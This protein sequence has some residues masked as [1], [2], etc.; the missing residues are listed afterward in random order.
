MRF[1]SMELSELRFLW[2]WKVGQD[3]KNPP[4]ECQP[5]SVDWTPIERINGCQTA[6]V[7]RHR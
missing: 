5:K 7:A 4:L 6:P 2:G 3:P 1:Y